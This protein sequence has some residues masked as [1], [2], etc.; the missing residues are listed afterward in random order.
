MLSFH[1]AQLLKE[2]KAKIVFDNHRTLP[3]ECS[4]SSHRGRRSSYPGSYLAEKPKANR[5]KS[6]TSKRNPAIKDDS[7]EIIQTCRWD[8]MPGKSAD[9]P[10]T[11]LR[12][13]ARILRPPDQ[14]YRRSSDQAVGLKVPVRRDS[15]DDMNTADL[16]SQVLDELEIYDEEDEHDDKTTTT[17]TTRTTASPTENSSVYSL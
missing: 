4:E 17:N 13:T 7:F 8:S 1:L 15:N 16:I 14:P 11:N 2:R 9:I 10:Q 6:N 3:D 12:D 5:M